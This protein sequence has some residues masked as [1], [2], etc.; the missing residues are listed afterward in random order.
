[1]FTFLKLRLLYK[2]LKKYFSFARGKYG[3]AELFLTFGGAGHLRPASGTWGSFAALPFC[4]LLHF[5]YG[6]AALIIAAAALYA[7]AIPIIAFHEK[8]TG[9]HDSSYIV[10]DEVIG[11]LIATTTATLSFTSFVLA[12][13]LFRAFDALKPGPIGWLDKN[14]PGAHGVLLDD[15]MAGVLA[16]AC[17]FILQI[18]LF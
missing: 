6:P 4:V 11:M 10:I 14:M 1:M 8:G 3:L 9:Q 5:F 16:A 7:I 18:V 2:A 12:F 17:V 15:V 13:V